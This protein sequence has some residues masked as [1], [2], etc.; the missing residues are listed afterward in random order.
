M[1]V[2][3]AVAR[4]MRA[5]LARRR[6]AQAAGVAR[7]GWKLAFHDPAFQRR[8]GLDG[9]LVGALPAEAVLA[10]GAALRTGP[11]SKLAVEAEIAIRIAGPAAEPPA[12]ASVAPALEI[13]DYGLPARDLEAMAGHSF[14]HFASVFGAEQPF[15]VALRPADCVREVRRN[16]ETVGGVDPALAPAALPALVEKVAT[17]LGVHGESLLPGDRI[18][19]GSLVQP[20]RVGPGDRL[21]VDF[22]AW[23][24]LAVQVAPET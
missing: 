4:G 21:S 18:L 15:D 3:D 20:V 5:Q 12:I 9:P 8:L 22:G 7:L 2:A 16:G 11:D 17:L 1:A 13:V 6:A 14:F 23:G 24:E 10:P 19:A